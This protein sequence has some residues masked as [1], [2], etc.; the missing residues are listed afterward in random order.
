M[1][2][3]RVV[4]A[5]AALGLTVALAAPAGAL[6]HPLHVQKDRDN[7]PAGVEV[8]MGRGNP[9]GSNGTIKID[10]VEFD[11]TFDGHPNNEPH[12]GNCVFQVD[13]YGFD[14]GDTASLGFK[15]WPPSG[16]KT[17]LGVSGFVADPADGPFAE[18]AG[19]Q[20]LANLDGTRLIDINVGE[21]GAGGGID[22]DNQVYVMLSG[23][24]GAHPQHGYH[25]KVNAEITSGN[26]TYTKTKV[27][28]VSGGC[29]P[30]ST[31]S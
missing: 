29:E 17:D 31:G 7:G 13:F 9:N 8:G 18:N 11:G 12:V 30:T 5:F 15:L 22:I 21:D 3:S 20:L 2:L 19:F 28:W 27:F 26:R 6:G 25:V 10:G 1:R 16:K 4:S 24:E 23:L 14:E